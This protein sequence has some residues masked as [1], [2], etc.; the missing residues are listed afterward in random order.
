MALHM[1]GILLQALQPGH[2]LDSSPYKPPSILI[3]IGTIST[4]HMAPM[5]G[6]ENLGQ[7]VSESANHSVI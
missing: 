7:N 3:T 5:D 4:C 6:W 1:E 2:T